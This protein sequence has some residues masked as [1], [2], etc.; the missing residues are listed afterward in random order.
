VHTRD[1]KLSAQ[2][3]QDLARDAQGGS[4]AAFEQLA[5]RFQGPLV[6]F[7]QRKFPSLRD[8]E[9]IS[10]ETLIRAYRSLDKYHPGHSFRTWLFTIAYRLAVSHNRK[11]NATGE[12][13]NDV[14]DNHL[15]PAHVLE[16]RDQRQRIWATAQT[17]LSEEQQSALWLYYVEDL[18]IQQVAQVL[19]RTRIVIKVMLHRARRKLEP[20]LA[21]ESSHEKVIIR[22]G[23]SL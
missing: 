10:Q 20:Y 9:D 1:E 16:K 18:S 6:G 11:H 23:G 8:A 4:I 22:A 5:R 13:S 12:L 21:N 14:Q 17:I 7:L 19:G 2:A 3:D 15:D